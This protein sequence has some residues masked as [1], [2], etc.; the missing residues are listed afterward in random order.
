MKPRVLVLRAPGT[1]CDQETA[2]AFSLAGAQ[3]QCVHIRE[4]RANSNLFK[5]FQIFV[6]PGGFTYG[7]DAGAGT[8]LALQLHH[9]LGD[10][11]REFRDQ[12]KLI[13]GI[14]NG[15]QVL[16]KSGLLLPH[17][18]EG[19]IATLTQNV[20]GRYLDTWV[21]LRAFPSNCPFLAAI[22]RLTLPI[23]HGEG[24]F[25]VRESWI[26]EGIAQAGQAVLRFCPGTDDHPSKPYNPNGSELD[27]AGLCDV[28]GQV[29]GLMPHPERFMFPTQ[30][31]TWT[32]DGL[33]ESADGLQ[34]FRNAVAW[35]V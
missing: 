34:I 29:F 30:N 28:T 21:H 15:F 33:Q 2:H 1:N 9:F 32:R 16:L 7:D 18:E 20:G 4:L 27:L 11:L 24:R 6:I 14:C 17:D 26:R 10:A 12:G 35:F 13:L 8:L 25:V 5:D 22:D 19:P 3:P 23:A 31:P